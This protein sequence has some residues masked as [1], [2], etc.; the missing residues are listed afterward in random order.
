MFDEPI[1]NYS[2]ADRFKKFG[3]K[4]ALFGF[5]KAGKIQ[6]ST[7]QIIEKDGIPGKA[8]MLKQATAETFEN[9]KKGIDL[10][11]KGVG[12]SMAFGVLM[13]GIFLV[14]GARK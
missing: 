4:A 3:F 10:G 12:V 7:L 1:K 14:I 9:F 13:V 11:V 5:T 6:N 2:Y 8:E